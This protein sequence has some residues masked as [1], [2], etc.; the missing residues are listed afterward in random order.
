VRALSISGQFFELLQQHFSPTSRDFN[1]PQSSGQYFISF[2]CRGHD[3]GPTFKVGDAF[4]FV[5]HVESSELGEAKLA[6]R[7]VRVEPVLLTGPAT[8]RFL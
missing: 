2:A 5:D 3:N 6:L 1:T 4:G 8:G 7:V